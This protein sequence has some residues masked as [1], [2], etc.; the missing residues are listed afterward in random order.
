MLEE[1]T[2]GPGWDV[3]EAWYLLAKAYHMQGRD[4]RERDCLVFALGLAE[5]RG[6]RDVGTAIGSSL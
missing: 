1:L 5:F 2:R 3:A 6:I 4:D